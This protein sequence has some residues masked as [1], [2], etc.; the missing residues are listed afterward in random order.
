[1]RR[2][3]CIN[4]CGAS[5]K[6]K[7][8]MLEHSRKYCERRPYNEGSEDELEGAIDSITG[9]ENA[10]GKPRFRKPKPRPKS[11][12]KVYVCKRGCGTEYRCNKAM[13][14]HDEHCEYGA[15][16]EEKEID[17]GTETSAENPAASE[18]EEPAEHQTTTAAAPQEN[19]GTAVER[20]ETVIVDHH[21]HHHHHG[22]INFMNIIDMD[23]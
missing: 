1:M 22:V 10:A 20:N 23:F 5:Y 6:R 17:V 2:F 4:G 9:D 14:R 7:T 21:H 3:N 12:K 11:T 15:E 16:D 18:R 8:S 13:K 19:S